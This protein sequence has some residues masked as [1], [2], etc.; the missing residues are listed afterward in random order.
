MAN[1]NSYHSYVT[2]K[3][4]KLNFSFNCCSSNLVYLYDC[5]VDGWCH[6]LKHLFSSY[7]FAKSPKKF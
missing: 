7:S 1:S 6:L 5:V 3:E 4:Y 2:K